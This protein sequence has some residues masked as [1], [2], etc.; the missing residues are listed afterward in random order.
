[1]PRILN[2]RI[3]PDLF[4]KSG[5]VH[6]NEGLIRKGWQ[7]A[8]FKPRFEQ[9][10]VHRAIILQGRDDLSAH[11]CGHNTGS[12]IFAPAYYAIDGFSSSG[13]GVLPVQ[14]GIYPGFVYIRNPVMRSLLKLVLIFRN[15]YG[16]LLAIAFR[17]FF[18][19]MPRRLY[20]FL[21]AV[22]VQPKASATSDW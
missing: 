8:S 20:A 6:H 2:K 10:N 19:V 16:V 22:A 11:L 12:L 4:M 9:S 13:V 17:L 15:L 1:M 5:V 18:R 14:I 3:Q 21:T 7:Q